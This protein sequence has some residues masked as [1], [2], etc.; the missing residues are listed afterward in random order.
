MT[1]GCLILGWE[2]PPLVEGGLGRHVGRLAPALAAHGLAVHVLTRGPSAGEEEVDGV[3]VHRVAEP[4][5]PDDMTRFVPWIERMAE[6]MLAAGIDL[7][8]RF[9]FELVHGHDWLVAR[10]ADRLASR[11]GCPLVM[12]IHATEHGRHRGWV[13]TEPQAHIHTVECQAVHGA[14][15][16]IVCSEYMRGHL[17]DV[18]GADERR[19]RVIPNG[20]EGASPA[21]AAAGSAA[22]AAAVRRRWPGPAGPGEAVVLLAGR[23]VYEK[24]FQ[25][26]FAALPRLLECLGPAHLVVAGAGIHEDALRAQVDELGLG[27]HVSF[28]GWVAPADLDELYAAADVCLVPS[29][30]EPF[31]LVALEAMARGCPCVVADTGGLREIV[32]HGE[33][34]LRFTSGDPVSLAAM[35][36]LV[37]GDEPLRTRLVATAREHV[38]RFDWTAIAAR[39]AAVYHELAG[40]GAARPAVPVGPA[41]LG[42]G[43]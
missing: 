14:D 20:V 21:M 26:A 33:A 34:G 6:D 9:D 32:P 36:E 41:G 1:G 35:V 27:N 13:A 28:L 8:R 37:L 19:I 30:Y 11:F 10:A 22:G 43:E 25:L 29:I 4:A 39:T 2:Y 16:L 17:A 3:V 31:G 5:R 38:A 42:S 24:G 7:A 40:R 23:L 18:F 15:R 12:T